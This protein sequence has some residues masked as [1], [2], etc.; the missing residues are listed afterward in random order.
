MRLEVAMPTPDNAGSSFDHPILAAALDLAAR[1]FPVFPVNREK[2]PLVGTRGYKDA[3]TAREPIRGWFTNAPG[4]QLAVATGNGLLVVDL[5]QKNGADGV[6]SLAA[7]QSR[8]DDLPEAPHVRTPSGGA[9]LWFQY[10][11]A[12]GLR[13]SAGRLG[14]GID[15]RADGGYVVVPPSLLS[16]GAGYV[17]DV[18]LDSC[19]PP[20]APRWLLNLCIGKPRSTGDSAPRQGDEIKG[21]IHAALAGNGKWHDSVLRVVAHMVGKGMDDAIILALAPGL[22]LNGWTVEQT[23]DELQEMIDGARRKGWEPPP[24]CSD[25]V[26]AALLASSERKRNTASAGNEAP[27]HEP[28]P[29]PAPEPTTSAMRLPD[30]FWRAREWLT[31]LRNYARG[32]R[33]NEITALGAALSRVAAMLPPGSGF[34][35]GIGGKTITPM[36]LLCCIVAV[37]GGAKTQ[38]LFAAEEMVPRPTFLDVE[39]ATV[40]SGEGIVDSFMGSVP[41]DSGKGSTIRQVRHNA[42]LY[43]DEGEAL[44]KLA[45]QPSNTTLEILRSAVSGAPI[46][47]A[48]SIAG[49]RRRKATNYN[50]GFCIGLQ[51]GTVAPLLADV[52]RGTPQRALFF[53]AFASLPEAW[54]QAPMPTIGVSRQFVVS[55]VPA[56]RDEIRRAHDVRERLRHEIEESGERDTEFEWRSHDNVQQCKVA[57]LFAVIDGR[58]MATADDWAMAGILVGASIATRT[59]LRH[60]VARQADAERQQRLTERADGAAVATLAANGAQ[61]AM[62]AVAKLIAAK[63]RAAAGGI[64]KSKARKA[65]WINRRHLFD[66]ALDHAVAA[67][68]VAMS[69]AHIV[70]GS[71]QP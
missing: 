36:N 50:V 61:G 16:S 26:L 6:A 68:W 63:A 11:P 48:N 31:Q 13:C 71:V 57:A 43:M 70:P 59:W 19:D 40:G 44:F 52:G 32:S 56:V 23:R 17:W 29:E 55:F 33:I 49:G 3:T 67:G 15:V 47:T 60:E 27:E 20:P 14:P 45:A 24:P 42:W 62:V 8:Y 28:E 35:S 1:G 58:D 65:I 25:E 54:P 46:G 18:D 4:R 53:R 7:L 5:D 39:E 22:T 51:P 30:R 21:L 12:L 34:S 64:S 37:S 66:A 9:H 38:A 10:D 2:K 69:D 41:N